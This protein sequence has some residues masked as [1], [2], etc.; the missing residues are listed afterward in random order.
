MSLDEF[1]ALIEE[2]DAAAAESQRQW[3][4]ACAANPRL[5]VAHALVVLEREALE[6]RERLRLS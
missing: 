2:F 4:A 5:A 1:D 6:A 3:A